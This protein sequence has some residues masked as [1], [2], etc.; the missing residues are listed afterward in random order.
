MEKERI[1]FETRELEVQKADFFLI[2]FGKMPEIRSAVTTGL[3]YLHVLF[4][5]I[6][7]IIK[8]PTV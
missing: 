2:S 6:I 5:D 3:K 7:N 4:Y 1:D 8:F